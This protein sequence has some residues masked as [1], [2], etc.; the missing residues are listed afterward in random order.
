MEYQ[1]E[2]LPTRPL[3]KERANYLLALYGPNEIDVPLTPILVKMFREVFGSSISKNIPL[4]PLSVL[5]ISSLQHYSLDDC[6]ILLL[7]FGY[8]NLLCYLRSTFNAFLS[9]GG[10]LP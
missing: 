2:T 8:F 7:C 10:W 4:D 5:Y 6:G 3:T 9:Q 1:L